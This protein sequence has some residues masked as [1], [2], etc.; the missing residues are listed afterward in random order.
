MGVTAKIAIGFAAVAV[1]SGAGYE[2]V[3]AVHDP[4]TPPRQAKIVPAAV[5]PAALPRIVVRTPPG[6]A[7]A[8]PSVA[9][10]NPKAARP[11]VPVKGRSATAP[12]H[13]KTLPQAKTAQKPKPVT[14]KQGKGSGGLGP[15]IAPARGKSPTARARVHPLVGP[16]PKSR[17]GPVTPPRKSVVA[18]EAQDALAARGRP[19]PGAPPVSPPKG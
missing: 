2:G 6:L 4:A 1:A 14:A 8:K 12:G 5:P 10:A 11:Q 13:T 16:K 9:R 7:R 17:T 19:S 15:A 18:Q 3:K